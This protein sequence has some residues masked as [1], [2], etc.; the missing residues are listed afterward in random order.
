MQPDAFIN[1]THNVHLRSWIEP[2]NDPLSD[3]P[4][5]NLPYCSV[6]LIGGVAS[7]AV[8]IGDQVVI[9]SELHREGLLQAEPCS[10]ASVDSIA[11]MPVDARS[12]LRA[13]LSRLFSDQSKELSGRPD[14]IAKSFV[15]LASAKLLLPCTISNYT[16][17]YASIHHASTVG[18]MFRPDNPLLPNYKHIPIGYHGRASTLVPHGTPIRRPAGQQSPPDA[19]PSDGPSFGPCKMLDHELEVGCIIAEGNNIGEPIAVGRA[20]ANILGLCLVNDW[21]ARDMQK[22]EYQPLGPFLAKNFATTLSPF[23]ITT[24]ALAP[25]RCPLADRPLTDPAPLPYLT[26]A[27]DLAFGGFDIVL[28]V[29]LLS[30]KMRD[31]S[32]APHRISHGRGFKDMYWTFAQMIAHHTSNGCRLLP[33]DLLA[34]GTVSGE[35]P[36]SRGCMLELSWDGPGKPRKPITLPT[37]ETRT[38]LADGDIITFK[39]YC[40]RAGFRRVG[41]GECS[42]LVLPSAPLPPA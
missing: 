36:E 35:H 41:F 37:G 12:R 1:P 16:D 30:Q 31:A 32:I 22:W 25:F 10:L 3:F 11:K 29:Y 19:S 20:F 8:A 5:Q 33:G 13:Q 38:F 40:E 17:F 14:I 4:V 39:G 24:E 34:S 42:G 15:P 26:S 23:I 18:A 2:A 7:A 9:L 28:E 6:E 27:Q 21:S